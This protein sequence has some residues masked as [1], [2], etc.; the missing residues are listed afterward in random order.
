MAKVTHY[1]RHYKGGKYKL[2]AIAQDSETLAIVVVYQALYG[3]HQVWVRPKD[4]FFGTVIKDGLVV[5]RF[6]EITKEEA[7]V[8]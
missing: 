1:Y 3:N 2:V 4:M 6:T 7:Y 5:E 8:D